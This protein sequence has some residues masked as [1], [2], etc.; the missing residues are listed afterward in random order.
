MAYQTAGPTTGTKIDPENSLRGQQLK[1]NPIES[2]VQPGKSTFEGS[3]FNAIDMGQFNPQDMGGAAG[4]FNQRA[5]GASGGRRLEFQIDPQSVMENAMAAF[6]N[7]LPS[8]NIDFADQSDKLAKGTAAMGRTGSGLF[9]RDTG[10]L[11]DRARAKRES[12]LGNLGF[13][14]AQADQSADLQSQI[15]RQQLLNAQE[16][17]MSQASIASAQMANQ[18]KMAQ[19]ANAM[20]AMMQNQSLGQNNNQF[21]ALHGMMNDQF[22]VGNQMNTDMFNQGQNMAQNQFGAQFD[23]GQ[24]QYQNQLAQQAQQDL[25]NQMQMLQTGFGGDPTAAWQG[26]AGGMMGGAGMYGNQA[27]QANAGIGDMYQQ[28]MQMF[29]GGGNPGQ[30]GNPG[31]YYQI[32]PENMPNY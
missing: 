23:V 6:Q 13:Q 5:S 27:G 31:P 11:S 12:L 20:Q 24:Q 3:D 10:Y 2:N 19:A 26:A 1:F 4:V 8:L 15:T 9:N 17:R 14:G 25:Y 18:M 30:M 21:N 16:G 29:G 22:N 7:Q 32:P 28:M